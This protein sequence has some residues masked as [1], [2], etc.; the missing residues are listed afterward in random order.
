MNSK[1]KFVRLWLII[2]IIAGFATVIFFITNY[3]QN[4]VLCELHCAQKNEITIALIAIGLFGLFIG[5]LTYFFI[6][7][8]KE[9]EINEAYKETSKG[10]IVTLNFLNNEEKKIMK[11]IIESKEQIFQ[12]KLPKKT[13]L[14]R[15]AISRHINALEKKQ[16]VQKRQAGMTNLIIMESHLKELFGIINQ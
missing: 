5:S 8:K 1:S 15:V 7:E 10:A 6:T 14:T 16:V 11:A 3:L 4:E 2:G 13:G 9:K 12:S